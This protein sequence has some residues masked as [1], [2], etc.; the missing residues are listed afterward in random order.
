MRVIELRGGF[1]LDH[2]RL[3]ERPEPT[4]G[5]GEVVVRMRAASLNYR[6]WLMVTGRY[7]P[8]QPLPLVPLSDGAGEVVAVGPGVSRVRVGDRVASVFAQRWLAGPPT[9]E[10]LGSTLGGPREGVLGELVALDAEGVC[11]VPE[12]LSFEEAA[13]LPCAAVTAWSALAQAEVKPG[14]TVLVQGTGGVSLFALLLAKLR[15]ACVI[16]TSKSAE[17]LA[18]ARAMGADHALDYES[19]PEW[20][21]AARAL[22][23]GRGVDTII[24]VG[25]GGTIAQSLKAVR[26]GGT[27]AVIGVL[28]GNEA[29]VSL[30]PLLMQNVRMQG[31]FVGSRT[32]QEDLGRAL[33]H[34]C[35]RPPIDSVVPWTSTAEALER[36]ARGEHF[37]K[38]VLSIG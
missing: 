25:G 34:A 5:P 30:L 20:G 16:V 22:T 35:L 15:G 27:V 14:D 10:A 21:K 24:E 13:T 19:E 36:L 1:G 4:P 33:A 18:R 29:P 38:V 3:T 11:T 6:D 2:L 26:P 9:K 8:R 28:A 31:V 37:G 12:H 17:K 32:D 7:N 23:G